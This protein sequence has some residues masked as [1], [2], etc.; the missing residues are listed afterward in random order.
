MGELV[1]AKKQESPR[2]QERRDRNLHG[3]ECRDVGEARAQPAKAVED[4]RLIGH[5]LTDVAQ[6]VGERLE[7]MAV[8]G[9]GE[10]A[11]GDGPELRLEVDGAGHLVVEEEVADE[12]GGLEGGL[13]F[14]HDGVKDVLAD[15][16]VEPPAN[17]VVLALPLG[18]AV[19]ARGVLGDVAGELVLAEENAHEHV[20]LGEIGG[21]E[22]KDDGNVRFHAGDVDGEGGRR[23]RRHH[24]SGEGRGGVGVQSA[25]GHGS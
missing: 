11:L 12:R 15:G 25:R 16:A 22:V 4:Q 20:P 7:P 1:L 2:L 5:R 17:D 18:G 23:D 10:V 8:G 3:D 6:S 24:G 13:V 9:D 21:L 19:G 14:R